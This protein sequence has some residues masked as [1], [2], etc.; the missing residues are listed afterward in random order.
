M[1]IVFS[2]ELLK[3][4]LFCAVFFDFIVGACVVYPFTHRLF[5]FKFQLV[6]FFSE[7]RKASLENESF[8]KKYTISSIK[9][10]L[11]ELEDIRNNTVLLQTFDSDEHPGTYRMSES[12]LKRIMQRHVAVWH[13]GKKKVVSNVTDAELTL[14][15]YLLQICD[16]R[17]Q[18]DALHW[19]EVMELP[20]ADGRTGLFKSNRTFYNALVGLRD[21]G[22]ISYDV[23]ERIYRN[24]RILHND[25]TK[26]HPKFINL[27]R[28][29]FVHS[30]EAY[31]QFD[32]LP[33]GAKKI[34]LYLLLNGYGG[35]RN[36]TPSFNL[37]R[38]Q[39]EMGYTSN[40]LFGAYL[41]KIEEIFG[42]LRTERDVRGHRRGNILF[43]ARENLNQVTAV[44]EGYHAGQSNYF[45]RFV[46]RLLHGT[47][48]VIDCTHDELI[49]A[50]CRCDAYSY[51][52]NT[53]YASLVKAS[54]LGVDRETVVKALQYLL[55]VSG[56]L[57]QNTVEDLNFILA[58]A[59]YA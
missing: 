1:S 18:V 47:G 48:S 14:L 46:K 54:E 13:N 59:I 11:P 50:T 20:L 43:S 38:L 55:S 51:Y 5:L 58:R 8:F 45:R 40:G 17:N 29:I 49:H 34:V 27:N 23:S 36:F 32:A 2:T 30:H 28:Y 16:S 33:L 21:K 53:I 19:S 44:K 37:Y 26:E 7:R 9:K 57:G 3:K 24:I 15:I 42:R 25:C 56:T 31:I 22:Y 4:P 39:R 6:Q 10:E 52:C 12:L 35:K 41:K